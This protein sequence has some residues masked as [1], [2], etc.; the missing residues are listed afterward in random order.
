MRRRRQVGVSCSLQA[1]LLDGGEHRLCCRAARKE[2]VTLGSEGKVPYGDTTP[3]FS[4]A[5]FL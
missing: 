1:A 3:C 4:I 2:A 5:G